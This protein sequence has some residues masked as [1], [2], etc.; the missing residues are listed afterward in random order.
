MSAKTKATKNPAAGKAPA[1]GATGRKPRAAKAQPAE[2][3]AAAPAPVIIDQ[4]TAEPALAFAVE[5]APTLPAEAPVAASVPEIVA[6]TPAAIEITP[7]TTTTTKTPPPSRKDKPMTTIPSFDFSVFQTAFTDI[8]TKAKAAM[9]KGT[10]A[11]GEYNA[12]AKGN[13]EAF[14][15]A[16]KI[17]TAGLQELGTGAVAESRTAFETLTTE[18]KELAAAKSPTE[19]LRLQSELAKKHIDHAVAVASKQSEALLKLTNDAAAPVS[20]RVAV[21]VSKLQKAA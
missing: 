5:T 4:P 15:E 1:A 9:E 21:T 14:V 13:V 6:E 2:V 18:V 11:F 19:F 20:N 17:L 10:A 12:I 3:V 8:Q 7:T 16:G